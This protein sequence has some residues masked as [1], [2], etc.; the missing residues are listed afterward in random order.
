[1]ANLTILYIIPIVLFLTLIILTMPPTSCFFD[2]MIPC[3]IYR[4]FTIAVV[5]AAI[6]FLG[7]ALVS[8]HL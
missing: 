3:P 4:S 1:M 2:N 7:V 6:S 8:N 5:I